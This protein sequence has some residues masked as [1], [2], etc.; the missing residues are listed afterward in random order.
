MCWNVSLSLKLPEHQTIVLLP[1]NYL[2]S[3]VLHQAILAAVC[4]LTG[5]CVLRWDVKVNYTRKINHFMLMLIPFVLAWWLPYV[6]NVPTTIASLVTFV[7]MTSLFLPPIRNRVPLVATAFASVDRPEDRPHTIAWIMSQAV[8]A[9]L[10]ILVV[11][12]TLR[13]LKA[14]ELIAIPLLINGIGDGL[15]EPI[16]IRFGRHRYQ[17]PSLA[18]GRCYTRS[19]E[20]SACV[21]VTSVIVIL[22]LLPTLSWP[23]FIALVTW[24]PPIMTLTE[25]F[26]P[27]S[28]DAPFMYAMGG[29]CVSL[30]LLLVG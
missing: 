15:A 21:W 13:W 19:Y 10:V 24:V 23:V 18:A 25:A 3:L 11:F 9:Y 20:G 6:P 17:V 29:A 26:S 7:T 28:W 1:N 30:V 16:G 22:F 4:Y 12:L 5:W 14:P 8:A 27:H 2:I